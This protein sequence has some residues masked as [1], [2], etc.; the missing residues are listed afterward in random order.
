[1]GFA[2]TRNARLST[3]HAR[4]HCKSNW[5]CTICASCCWGVSGSIW[6]KWREK[7]VKWR[8]VGARLH[9]RLARSSQIVD[10]CP[11]RIRRMGSYSGIL[12]NSLMTDQNASAYMIAPSRNGAPGNSIGALGDVK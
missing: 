1:M 9:C 12:L 4:N 10:Q 5:D 8:E 3:A 7:R 11:R 6:P 2:P